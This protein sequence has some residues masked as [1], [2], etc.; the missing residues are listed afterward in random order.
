MPA[1]PSRRPGSEPDP[2]PARSVQTSRLSW[3][4]LIAGF[5]I[6]ATGA[7]F[8]WIGHDWT[9][10]SVLQVAVGIWMIGDGGRHLLRRRRLLGRDG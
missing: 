9:W 3:F 5:C 7:Y 4:T 10:F 8:L 2:G 6:A 1:D